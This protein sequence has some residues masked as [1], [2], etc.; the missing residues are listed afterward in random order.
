MRCLRRRSFRRCWGFWVGG[1]EEWGHLRCEPK[2]HLFKMFTLYMRLLCLCCFMASCTGFQASLRI[3]RLAKDY[4]LRENK[5]T[6][7]IVRKLSDAGRMNLHDLS[8]TLRI[9]GFKVEGESKDAPSAHLDLEI[10][11][12]QQVS[13][14]LNG[15]LGHLNTQ[16]KHKLRRLVDDKIEKYGLC[17]WVLI[18]AKREESLSDFLRLTPA[19]AV[20]YRMSHFAYLKLIEMDSPA[21]L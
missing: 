21:H 14:Y 16:Q 9:D 19:D 5:E 4:S 2:I 20:R 8:Q 6:L 18:L 11:M 3:N 17:S 1:G 12:I 13:I 15:Q 7:R 10:L